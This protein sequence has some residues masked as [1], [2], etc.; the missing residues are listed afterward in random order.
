MNQTQQSTNI[1]GKADLNMQYDMC[2]PKRGSGRTYNSL[3]GIGTVIGHETK[4][5][6]GCQIRNKQCRKC[7]YWEGKGE[8]VPNHECRKNWFGTSKAM[9]PDAAAEIL[10]EIEEH[11]N[12][13]IKTMIMD[14]DATTIARI[15]AELNHEVQK[16]SDLNHVK[17]GVG[18][19]L[20]KLNK[21][22]PK[23]LN[24]ENI[25]Y[26][27][28][29]FSYAV[30]QNKGKAE[31][32]KQAILN[33]VPHVFGQHENCTSWCG[34]VRNP[35]SYKHK[36]LAGDFKNE[37][38]RNHLEK[39]FEVFANNSAKIAP[40]AS[41]KENENFNHMIFSKAPKSRHYSGSGSL[42]CRVNCA[43]AQKNFGYS[44]ICQ[45]NQTA[46]LSPGKITKL[47]S[48]KRERKRKCTKDLKNTQSYKRKRIFSKKLNVRKNKTS[49]VKEGVTY[50]SNIDLTPVLD[51]NIEFIPDILKPPEITKCAENNTSHSKVYFDIETTSLSMECDLTQLSA[52][53]ACHGGV[54][55][56]QYI[57][58]EKSISPGAA[59]VTG[60][61]LSNG[62]LFHMGKPVHSVPVRTDLQAFLAFL[63]DIEP[64]PIILIG[65]NA[66]KFDSPRLS[67]KIMDCNL[68][69]AFCEL[70][71][72]YIDTLPYF[73]ELYP[74]LAK[75]NQ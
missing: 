39:I 12:V 15:R 11:H 44:Y 53:S 18:N 57:T 71:A 28:R 43:V 9:E 42:A 65:H 66:H 5:V 63:T 35:S 22:F 59:N 7:A 16:W 67:R 75:H 19:S 46:G 56:N 73:R 25:S 3:A 26:L 2:W 33:I 55:F 4:K 36:T 50:S 74:D 68:K 13:K 27:Q 30:R 31:N 58:P 47:E 1:E 24:S 17:K 20:W 8:M 60:L 34:Y 6:L 64:K 72:G 32:T 52:V 23:D 37:T 54:E 29:C 48:V 61:T 51:E 38:L 69:S 45:I 10:K 49:A 21:V 14:E 70:V 62:I 41:T 40:C